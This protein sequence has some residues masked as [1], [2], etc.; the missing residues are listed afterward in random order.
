MKQEYAKLILSL[1]LLGEIERVIL[2]YTVTDLP[3]GNE[4]VRHLL[5]VRWFHLP[6]GTEVDRN[7]LPAGLFSSTIDYL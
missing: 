5:P 1:Q 3:V 2:C 4:V 7:L 6:E